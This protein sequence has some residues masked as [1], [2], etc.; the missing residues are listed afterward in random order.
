MCI[1]VGGAETR[2]K[3]RPSSQQLTC[4]RSSEGAA[5]TSGRRKSRIDLFSSFGLGRLPPELDLFS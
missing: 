5:G 3:G 1:R 4:E 2:H